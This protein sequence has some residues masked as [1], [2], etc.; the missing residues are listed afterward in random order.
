MQIPKLRTAVLGTALLAAAVPAL[1]S[2]ADAAWWGRGWGGGWGWGGVGA[3]L[4]AG[5]IIGT[6]IAA[7]SY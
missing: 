5:A 3:G 2:S 7:N 6:A 1:P 4:A